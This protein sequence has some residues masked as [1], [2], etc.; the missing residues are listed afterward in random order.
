MPRGARG[1][2]LGLLALARAVAA[3]P[4]PLDLSAE[5]TFADA[6][7]VVVRVANAS[8]APLG[9]VVPEIRHRLLA[10][11]APAVD[12]AP[13]ARHEWRVDFPL[14]G[15]AE[16]DAL[17]VLVRWVDAAGRRRSQPYARLVETPGLL[18]TEAQVI[19]EPQVAEGFQL[20]T[21][22]ITN[23]TGNPLHG[24]LAAVLPEELFTTPEAQPVDVPP[25]QTL[26]V[27][28]TVQGA[29]DAGTTYPLFAILS[30]EQGGVPRAIVGETVLGVGG[31]PRRSRVRPLAVGAVGLLLAVGAVMLANR[32]VARRARR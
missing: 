13:G 11:T 4:L 2:A 17:I 26:R 23:A 5:A 28:I 29:A 10:R 8:G 30:F 6:V 18:P 12:L 24:R 9:A 22:Q 3:A 1:L 19:V 25:R 16:G 27:P 15:R 7:R 32:R 20:A 14:P 31:S 21:V